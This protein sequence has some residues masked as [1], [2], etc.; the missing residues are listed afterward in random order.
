[1]L[2]DGEVELDGKG[3]IEKEIEDRLNGK[4]AGDGGSCYV[5]HVDQCP[6]WRS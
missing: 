4:I 3:E 5:S 1:M 6:R 2:V